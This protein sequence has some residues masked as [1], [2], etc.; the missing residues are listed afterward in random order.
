MNS[1]GPCHGT[2]GSREIGKVETAGTGSPAI[3][4]VGDHATFSWVRGRA[5]TQ[6]VWLLVSAA[7][8]I[9]A[10]VS[11]TIFAVVRWPSGPQGQYIWFYVLVALAP[12]IAGTALYLTDRTIRIALVVVAAL[13]CGGGALAWVEVDRT[14]EVDVEME[15]QDAQP[16]EDS[17]G[18]IKVKMARP[19]P[20]DVRDKLRLKL[21]ISDE[22]SDTPTCVG[23]TTARIT[24]D[25]PGITPNMWEVGA[26]STVDFDLGG[27]RGAVQFTVWVTPDTGCSM[28]LT[29]AHGTLHN[30]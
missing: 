27:R 24:A 19:A 8:V 28:L 2:E 26:E 20:G 7:F 12:P 30:D 25:T 11:F 3:G 22:K 15:I 14:G 21:T 9:I 18:R 23:R 4:S 29:Q 16:V 10:T 13:C 1:A 6:D 5:L 17:G